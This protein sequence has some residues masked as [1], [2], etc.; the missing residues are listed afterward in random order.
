MRQMIHHL[1][2]HKILNKTLYS[3]K[4]YY[5]PDIE[6]FKKMSEKIEYYQMN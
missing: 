2:G 3:F 6:I 4:R 1:V 5:F